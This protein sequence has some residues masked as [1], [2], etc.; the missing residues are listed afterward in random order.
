MNGRIARERSQEIRVVIDAKRQ[1]FLAEQV[2]KSVPALTLDETQDGVRVAL[3]TNYLKAALP[4]WDVP[5]NRLINV[6]I[7]RVID[8]HLFGYAEEARTLPAGQRH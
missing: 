5:P 1:A 8:G 2:G 3:T 6:A 7:G 4:G